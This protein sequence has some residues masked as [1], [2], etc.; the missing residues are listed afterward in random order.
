MFNKQQMEAIHHKE[1]PL[2]I[3]AGPGS[4]KT[5]VI[6]NRTKTLIEEHKVDPKKILVSTFTKNAAMEM[7]ARFKELSSAKGVTFGTIH[8]IC[9]YILRAYFGYSYEKLCA[10]NEKYAKLYGIYKRLKFETADERQLIK[11]AASGISYIKNTGRDVQDQSTFSGFS[12][13]SDMQME[14]MYFAYIESMEKEEKYDFDDILLLCYKHLSETPD[15]LEKIQ[16]Q[17]QYIM[18]DEYQDTNRVQASIFYLIAEK[19]KNLAIVGDD[20]QSLYRFRAADPSIMLSFRKNFPDAKKVILATNYRSDGNIVKAARMFIETNSG[21]FAKNLEAN[22][23]GKAQIH[24]I[25]P[26]DEREETEYILNAVKDKHDSGTPYS[27]MAVIYRTNKESQILVNAMMDN[28][29]PFYAKKE[30]IVDIYSHF[31]YK[32]ILNFYEL[33]QGSQNYQK[34]QR[35]MKRPTQYV[36]GS[37]WRRCHSVDDVINA[38]MAEGK[39]R[40]ARSII[41]FTEQ[42]NTLGSLKKPLDII[43]YI[44]QVINYDKGIADYAEYMHE[45]ID[46][47]NSILD[48]LCEHAKKFQDMES[49]K[50]FAETYK[51]SLKE[52]TQWE[53]GTDAVTLT[54]M[55]GSKGLEYE[56]VFMVN[57]IDGITPNKGASGKEETEE[58]RRMF[59]VGMTR[60]KN[61]LCLFCP[62]KYQGSYVEESPFFRDMRTICLKLGLPVV[63]KDGQYVNPDTAKTGDILYHKKYGQGEVLDVNGDK[64]YLSFSGEFKIFPYPAALKEKHLTTQVPKTDG[65]MLRKD[66]FAVIRSEQLSSP[67]NARYVVIDPD[68]GE[69]IRDC[70]G[71]GYKNPESAMNVKIKRRSL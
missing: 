39:L 50:Q 20:D 10:E 54:T 64:I 25:H 40:N 34:W 18:I 52:Q 5:T 24:F 69:I 23:E 17:F 27:E 36:P 37:I 43:S 65:M 31:I 57:C 59:Y 70:S 58:E 45:S 6:V 38:M 13:I 2:L 44:R 21:R 30:D 14:K 42:I 16:E 7:E 49:W 26:A 62:K 28:D 4:G 32:D 56:T 46:I 1:G 66:G 35:A 71:Y 63:D 53:E 60:A 11:A 19:Y 47:L 3:I 61:E 22:R 68:S 15:V 29:I 48:M 67:G 33:S 41:K 8:S 12:G 55:H 9:L 51:E